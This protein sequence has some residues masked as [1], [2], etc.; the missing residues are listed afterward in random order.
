MLKGFLFA[1]LLSDGGRMF[2]DEK[3]DP[4]AYAEELAKKRKY[5]KLPKDLSMSSRMLYLESLPQEVKMEGD[6]VGLYTK[7]GT[8]VA[9]GYS[10][11]VIGDYGGFL[12]ISKQDMIR[13]S[14]CCK[15]GEQYRFK[16][17]KYKDSVK[18]YWYTAKDDSDIKIYFQQH[19]VSY[20]D[21]Q[22]GMFYISP[23]EL[24]I[25]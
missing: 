15:D 18:Y 9:T 8:K 13:E 7:S 3:I 19:G 1:L 2:L 25:K 14:L 20:A 16:D 12:E 11:T 17:P 21:Y 22:P 5:S 4:V 6:R 24:I 10:R 23:Y